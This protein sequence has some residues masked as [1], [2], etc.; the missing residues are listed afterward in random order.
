MGS[1]RTAKIGEAFYDVFTVFDFD[2]EST[3]SGQTSGDFT[4]SFF[5]D[6]DS[7]SPP[8][9]SISEIGTTG[10]YSLNIPGGLPSEGVWTIQTLVDY[11]GSTWQSQVEVRAHD[12]DDVYAIIVAGGSGAEAVTLRVLDSANGDLPIPGLLINVYNSTGTLFITFGRTNNSGELPLLLDTGEYVLRMYK[13]GVACDEHT[14]TV[15]SG[16]GTFIYECESIMVAPPPS[17][18][19]CRL[20]ADFIS[21]EGLPFA[22]FKLQVQNLFDPAA[23]SGLTVV[24]K[25]RTHE[26]DVNGHIEF[27]VVRGTRV[28]VAFITTPMT[29]TFVVPDKPVENILTLM[30]SATD[31]FQVVKK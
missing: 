2:L 15:P 28:S 16:G 25:V 24:D 20:Y 12:I 26:S 4:V 10:V 8:V 23:P 1:Y 14:L 31:T 11:N 7:A 27:D 29:R 17:P 19:L 22:K 18:Q 9:F 5:L 13:P 30:G 21:Q 3:V 6:D